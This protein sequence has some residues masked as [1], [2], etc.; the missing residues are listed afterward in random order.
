[1]ATWR[2]SFLFAVLSDDAW[3][4]NLGTRLAAIRSHKIYVK[5][6]PDR[7]GAEPHGVYLGCR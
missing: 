3:G 7:S 6:R 5:D 2:C 1:M 4:I